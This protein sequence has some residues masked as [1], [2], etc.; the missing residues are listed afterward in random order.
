MIL[1]GRG[2][3]GTRLL[4][5]FVQGQGVFL[6]SEI[7][8]SFDS[9][10]WVETIYPIAIEMLS[11]TVPPDAAR[12]SAHVA[13]LHARA[14][15]VLARAGLDSRAYWGWKLPETTLVCD[16]A[17]QAFPKAQFVHLVRHPVRASLRRTHMTSRM[18]NPIGRAALPAAYAHLGRDPALIETDSPVINNAHGWRHH[19]DLMARCFDGDPALHVVRFED[20]LTRPSE[21]ADA[22]AAFLH[23]A[24]P[25][26]AP[27]LAPD[28]ERAE[29]ITLDRDDA[30]RV[31]DICGAR[32]E[33]FGYTLDE[34]LD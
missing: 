18:N 9:V 28:P 15:E 31:W 13:R 34:V 12:R 1:L 29:P 30:H 11:A 7:N 10:E 14:E 27:P 16:I 20:T 19:V 32:A 23:R 8:K 4:S 24:P 5:E 22:L 21:T 33:G 3:G 26:D 25:P 2:G 6:G 17:K